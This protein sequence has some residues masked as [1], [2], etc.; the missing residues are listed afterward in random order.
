MKKL[1]VLCVTALIVC[2]FIFGKAHPINEHQK[3]EVLENVKAKK[4]VIKKVPLKE[5]PKNEKIVFLTFDDGPSQYTEQLIKVLKEHDIKATFFMQG[6]N[7]QN[8][9]LQPIVKKAS[10]QGNYIG[11]H[12]MTHDYHKLYVEGKFIQEMKS[13]QQLIKA[14]TG[15]HHQLVRAPYGSAPGLKDQAVRKQLA[16]ENIKLWD[17]N[18]DSEDWHRDAT[19][20]RILSTIKNETIQ[21]TEVVLMHEKPNTVK[22]LPSIIE[23]YK[24]QGYKFAVYGQYKHFEM[25]FMGDPNL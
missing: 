2:L 25:N 4:Q 7:L 10:D 12:S 1:A 3:E 14:I 16:K 8:K 21:N 18:I 19:P 17:W 6:V 20:Q 11:S 5:I 9:S 23:F 22:A 13:T 24:S 15:K